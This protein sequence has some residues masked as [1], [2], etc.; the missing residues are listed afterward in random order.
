MLTKNVVM[1]NAAVSGVALTV[2]ASI[3]GL[4]FDIHLMSC[5]RQR[6]VVDSNA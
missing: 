1:V 2:A 6:S 3:Q 4:K 5:Q